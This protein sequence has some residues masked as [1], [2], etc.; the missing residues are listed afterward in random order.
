MERIQSFSNIKILR[1]KIV[2]LINLIIMNSI[3]QDQDNFHFG[4]TQ[5][6]HAIQFN[7]ILYKTLTYYWYQFCDVM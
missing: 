6:W 4:S 1:G 5:L 7:V 2:P 3:D